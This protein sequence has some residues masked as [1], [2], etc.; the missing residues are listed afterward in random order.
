MEQ[1]TQEE[2]G[3]SASARANPA[4]PAVN[5]AKLVGRLTNAPQVTNHG[6]GK[7]RAQFSLA[8]PRPNQKA[9]EKPNYITV[10]GWGAIAKQCVDLTKGDAVRVEG[11]INTFDDRE[12]KRFLWGIT[13]NAIHVLVRASRAGNAAPKQEELAGV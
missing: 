1:K 7:D 13:A 10:V 6:P 2:G 9:D 12:N 5:E 4:L 8:V 3:R 11:R